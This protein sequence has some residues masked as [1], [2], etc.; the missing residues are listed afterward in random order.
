[1]VEFTGAPITVTPGYHSENGIT[2]GTIVTSF[3]STGNNIYAAGDGSGLLRSTDNGF[4]WSLVNSPTSF[5]LKLFASHDTLYL[6]CDGCGVFRSVD[7]AASFQAINNG[8]PVNVIVNAFTQFGSYLYTGLRGSG[9][10]VGVYRTPVS[11]INWT[12]VNNG[13]INFPSVNDL[14]AKG[15]DLWVSVKNFNDAGVFRSKRSW[16]YMDGNWSGYTW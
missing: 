16:R 7:E 4:S 6:G 11:V 1:M 5:I 14:A 3:A 13:L 2:E 8:F 9:G 15:N 10:T 12:Q